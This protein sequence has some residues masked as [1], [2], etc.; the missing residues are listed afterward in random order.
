MMI[1]KTTK[2]HWKHHQPRGN[3]HHE[4][5]H[6]IRVNQA[7]RVNLETEIN[8]V[9]KILLHQSQMITNLEIN[10]DRTNEL[11]INLEKRMIYDGLRQMSDEWWVEFLNSFEGEN[12]KKRNKPNENN[13]Y[14]EKILLLQIQRR[15]KMPCDERLLQILQRI[16][17]HER[18]TNYETI[19]EINNQ[20]KKI[21][22][23][24][25]SM[26]GR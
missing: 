23:R 24:I 20:N 1:S 14:H 21:P 13:N 17:S 15:I 7:T 22:G 11:K 9:V 25:C 2:N 8:L 16:R 3:H 19:S 26:M 6:E 4:S 12:E 10:L 18:M 5:E